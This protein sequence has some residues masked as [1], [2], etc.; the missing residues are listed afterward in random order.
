MSRHSTYITNDPEALLEFM[1]NIDSDFSDDEFDGYISDEETTPTTGTIEEEKEDGE[2]GDNSDGNDTSDDNNE[3]YEAA[4][5]DKMNIPEFKEQPGLVVDLSEAEPITFFQQLWTDELNHTIVNETNTYGDQYV[6]SHEDYLKSHPKS[7]VHD[8]THHRFTITELYNFLAIV[9]TMGIIS[10]PKIACY[11][12]TSWPFFTDSIRKIMSRDR[13]LLF[14]KFFHLNNNERY[15]SRGQP[16]FDRLFKVRPLISHLVSRYKSSYIPSQCVSVDESMINFR[17]RLSLL[18]Y[19]PKKPKKWGMKA[20]VLADSDNGYAWNWD[21]YTGKRDTSN[22]GLPLSSRVVLSLSSDLFNKGYNIYFDNF[23]TSPDLCRMLFEKGCGSCGTVRLNRRGI[24]KSFQL[25]KLKK[26]EITTYKDG[27]VLGLKWMDK[28]PVA[29]LST[30]HD[31]TMVDK[32]RRTQSSEEGVEVI[33]KPKMIE[34][35]NKYMGGVDKADQLVTYYGYPHFSKK[36]WKRVCFHLLD[37][38]LVNAYILYSQSTPKNDRLSHMDF[39]IE[40]ARSLLSQSSQ[41]RSVTPSA[42][43]TPLRLTGRH[44]PIPSMKRDCKVC[45]RRKS[46]KKKGK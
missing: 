43:H 34:E 8:F 10:F 32:Q 28:C 25:K 41:G 26:G 1:D 6:K 14:L 16:G 23:Y 13:F 2:R 17:G 12:R 4:I 46:G 40:V 44:F 21:L 7:R 29:V 11:W 42:S 30:I 45:S 20:W 38:T 18:Q 9:I 31:F 24:P 22:D 33:Q 39:Q 37:T 36:W 15:I 3:D 5:H 27:C 19:L 35:Y